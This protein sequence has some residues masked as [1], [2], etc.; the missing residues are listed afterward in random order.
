MSKYIGVLLLIAALVIAACAA[1][2]AAPQAGDAAAPAAGEAAAPSGEKVS[3]VMGSWRTDDVKQMEAIIAKFNE[4][5]PDIEIK[6]DPTNPPDYNATLRTQLEGGTG[7]DLLYL[8]SYATSRQLFADGFLES[9]ADLPGLKESFTDAA[10]LPWA[11]DDGASY[12]V[13]FIAVSHG[14]YYNKDIFTAAGVEV[15]TTW[16]ELL[17]AAQKIKDAGYIP[18]ANGA[19]EPWTMAEIVFMNLAP[20]FIGGFEGRQAYLKGER[21]F[22]DAGSVAA[23]QAV[24]DLAPFFPDGWEA[25]T[26]SDQQALF[27]TGQAAMWLGGSW[28]VPPLEAIQ[29]LG[30]EWGVF[31]IPAPEGQDKRYVTFHMDAGMGLNA[32]SQNKDAAKKFLEW[33]T[34]EEFATALANQLPGFFPISNT[35]PKIDNVHAAEFLALNE[36]AGVDVRWAWEKLLDGSPDGYT[37]MQDNAIAVATGEMT[38]Q[39]AADSLQTAG[40]MVRACAEVRSR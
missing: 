23:F 15:P 17:V 35:A 2:V 3:L 9:I 34:T 33:M 8:R 25:L 37:L 4:T 6:F 20:T 38:A 12:G 1:P 22:N 24:A 29:D 21:C 14:I 27:Q 11:T 18:F 19:G 40:H 28:D 30:F 36:G 32:A 39:E 31:G 13:P 5:Y 16:Q 26:Y 7:P 10:R